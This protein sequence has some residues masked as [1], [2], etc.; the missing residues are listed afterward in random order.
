MDNKRPISIDFK[1]NKNTNIVLLDKEAYQRYYNGEKLDL[2]KAGINKSEISFQSV[3]LGSGEYY[4]IIFD[5]EDDIYYKI[6]K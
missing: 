5:N 2:I 4:I 3:E 1:A 6:S